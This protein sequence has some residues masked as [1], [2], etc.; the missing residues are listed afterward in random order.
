MT[1]NS[2]HCALFAQNIVEIQRSHLPKVIRR[3]I[4]SI[5]FIEENDQSALNAAAQVCSKSAQTFSG[6]S[7]ACSL[8]SGKSSSGSGLETKTE[9]AGKDRNGLYEG[10]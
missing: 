4:P 5:F 6:S 3:G 10:R 1:I 2:C 9:S 8:S 7:Q